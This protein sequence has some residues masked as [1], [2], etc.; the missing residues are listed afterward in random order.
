MNNRKI[1]E[2]IFKLQAELNKFIGR[3]TLNCPEDKKLPWIWDY[4]WALHD[5]ATE[6]SNCF[7]WKFWDAKVKENENS[8]FEL[9]DLKNAKIELI[10]IIHFFISLCHLTIDSNDNEAIEVLCDLLFPDQLTNDESKTS[11]TNEMKFKTVKQLISVI[12]MILD[13]IEVQVKSVEDIIVPIFILAGY[14]GTI[15]VIL[16]MTPEEVLDV[17]KKKCLINFKRQKQQYR[18]DTKTEEDNI[19]LAD[20]L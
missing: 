16:D 12:M 3:D 7:R 11:I 5:E 17:Y 1:F 20:S 8:R 18:M 4:L 14:I 19:K 2:R 6:L 15:I 10:D 13:S 9:Y